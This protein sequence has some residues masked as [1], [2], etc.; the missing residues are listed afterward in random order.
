M[1]TPARHVHHA[2]GEHG[3]V[4]LDVR[5]RQWHMLDEDA[6]RIWHALVVRGGTTG[7]AEEIAIPTGQ[8]VQTVDGQISAFVG[9]LLAVGVLVDTDQPR[10][11]RRR[12]WWR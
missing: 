4:V 5:R 1:L 6:S 11:V 2:A 7:L 8:D 9:E 12:R 10:R 3:T